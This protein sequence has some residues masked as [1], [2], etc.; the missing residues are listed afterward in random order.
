MHKCVFDKKT[1]S[2]IHYL[3]VI[4]YSG[5]GCQDECFYK[6]D[7]SNLGK[8]IIHVSTSAGD[9]IYPF[10]F[11]NQKI[12]ELE[13]EMNQFDRQIQLEFI[14]EINKYLLYDDGADFY[15]YDNRNSNI[16][17]G[18]LITDKFPI[19]ILKFLQNVYWPFSTHW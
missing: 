7:G 18:F 6:V 10:S 14:E 5:G 13:I 16:K 8:S 1:K 11:K 9:F 12:V 3:V 2:F 4:G 17:S 15:F 19:K